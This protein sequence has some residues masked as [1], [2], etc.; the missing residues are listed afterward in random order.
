MLPK[1]ATRTLLEL[2][3]YWN[4]VFDFKT[5]IPSSFIFVCGMCSLQKLNVIGTTFIFKIPENFLSLFV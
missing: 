2:D 3:Y 4:N 1:I 5:I